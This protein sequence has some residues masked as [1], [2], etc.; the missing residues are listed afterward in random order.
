MMTTA[1]LAHRG[2]IRISGT[3]ART[4][5]QGLVTCNME[6]I[7]PEHAGFGALLSPQGKIL[8]DFLSM[9]QQ[10]AFCWIA[11]NLW[12]PIF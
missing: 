12:P 1:F 5:L 7:T 11:P 4:F 2:F 9:K 10:T 8:F 6:R 3:D